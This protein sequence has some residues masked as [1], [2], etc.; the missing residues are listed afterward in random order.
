M[1]EK[2]DS[3]LIALGRLV[4]IITRDRIATRGRNVV[5]INP[6]ITRDQAEKIARR[7]LL[8]RVSGASDRPGRGTL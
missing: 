3:A 8:Q 2:S 7:N 6:A 4:R 5:W 1:K